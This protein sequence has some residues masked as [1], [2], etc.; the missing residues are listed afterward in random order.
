MAIRAGDLP[1]IEGFPSFLS[2]NWWGYV[3]VVLVTFY[4]ALALYRQFWPHQEIEPPSAPAPAP[5]TESTLQLDPAPAAEPTQSTAVAGRNRAADDRRQLQRVIQSLTFA[6]MN[7]GSALA[8]TPPSARERA[9]ERE[10]PAMKAAL[11]SANKLYGIP[12]PAE[13]KTAMY[14]LELRR[15]MVEKILPFLQEGHT[16]E[17]RQEAEAFLERVANRSSG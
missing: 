8:D 2:A 1:L 10:M 17:A 13:G 12:I 3:P 5:A 14:D 7:A 11:L 15:R 4:L 16:E 6:H 9:A